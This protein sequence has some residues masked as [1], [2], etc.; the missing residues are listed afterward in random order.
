MCVEKIPL[1]KGYMGNEL[2]NLHTFF[3]IYNY[4]T[5]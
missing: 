4:D 3:A 5:E 2:N 1:K